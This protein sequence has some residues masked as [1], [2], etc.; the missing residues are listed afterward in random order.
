MRK[1]S[2]AGS[3]P[4]CCLCDDEHISCHPN[5]CC[6]HF[7]NRVTM[8]C[9]DC[10]DRDVWQPLLL[11]ISLHGNCFG[12]DNL[13][14]GLVKLSKYRAIHGSCNRALSAMSYS[15]HHLAASKLYHLILLQ[16]LP[17]YFF[18]AH[19]GLCVCFCFGLGS[20]YNRNVN[21]S[22]KIKCVTNRM[23][24]EKER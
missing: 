9:D 19:R 1:C 17:V 22:I 10:M 20:V 23:M 4:W 21:I 5:C 14:L 3:R 13:W 15:N 16:C 2:A 24:S 11:G 7:P 6:F 12:A 8:Q 18:F